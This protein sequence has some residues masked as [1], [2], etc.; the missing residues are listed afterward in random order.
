LERGSLELV[1]EYPQEF[2]IKSGTFKASPISTR[3]VSVVDY[4]GKLKIFDIETGKVKYDVQAHSKMA[5]VIDGIGGKGSE[6]GAPELVT[7]GSDGCV[8]VWDPRQE[9][10]VVSLEPADSEVVKPDCWA[11]CFGN[12]YNQTERCI[13]AGYD[14]GDCKVFDLKTNCLRWDTNLKNGICGIEFDRPDI[15]MN[16]MVVTTLESK[17]HVFDLKTY[18]PEK[19]YAGIEEISSGKATIWGLKHVPQNRDL[20][21]TMGGNGT[22]NIYKYH[23]P[24]SRSVK[25]QDNLD[26]GVP[27]KV[28]LLNEKNVAQQPIVGLDWNTDKIGLACTVSLD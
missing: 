8:R 28:E 22:L 21:A 15:A 17:F 14:N 7:G 18:H 19:G 9:S 3:D 25:D 11:V 23:Y 12:A 6:Y 27:G 1:K 2:G 26:M 13:V 4:Q 20:F 10:P 5:N 16:K 24:Q